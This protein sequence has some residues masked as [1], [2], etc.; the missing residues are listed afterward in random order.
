MKHT[1]EGI[2]STEEYFGDEYL[3][4]DGEALAEKVKNALG[5]T[6]SWSAEKLPDVSVHYYISP[7]KITE[8]EMLE[9]EIRTLA[10]DATIQYDWDQ[11]YS[12]WTPGGVSEGLT[13]G[14]HNLLEELHTHVGKYL[15][16]TIE[17]K[18]KDENTN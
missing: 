11:G 15:I 10:G 6:S 17:T 14:G 8:E 16:L 5:F 4:I 2:I 13:V 7:K 9:K 12:S 3:T 18:S 1:F